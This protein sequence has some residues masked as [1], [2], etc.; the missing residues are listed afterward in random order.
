[1]SRVSHLGV[2][3]L[4]QLLMFH[5]SFRLFC[6]ACSQSA[7]P[8]ARFLNVDDVSWVFVEP[9]ADMPVRATFCH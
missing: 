8:T 4:S 2:V 5:S 6:P 1:M 7:Q 3:L 9:V